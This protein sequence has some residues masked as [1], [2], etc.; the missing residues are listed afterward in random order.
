VGRSLFDSVRETTVTGVPQPVIDF[1]DEVVCEIPG[2]ITYQSIREKYVEVYKMSLSRTRL[3]TKFLEPLEDIGWLTHEPD[4]TDGRKVIFVKCRLEGESAET[5]DSCDRSYFRD[6]FPEERLKEYLG[7]LEEVWNLNVKCDGGTCEIE[8]GYNWF[9]SKRVPYFLE[10]DNGVE[11]GKKDEGTGK[12]ES[13]INGHNLQE[14]KEEYGTEQ[15]RLLDE[16]DEETVLQQ[17]P[18]DDTRIEDVLK[19]FEDQNRVV[20]TLAVLQ[21]KGKI[22]AGQG[23]MRRLVASGVESLDDFDV[24]RLS[25][26]TCSYC[27]ATFYAQEPFRNYDERAI[28]QKCWKRLI[29]KK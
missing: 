18:Q 6:I 4:P 24:S 1:Y 17:I 19:K 11:T 7:E 23:Y 9:F 14:K 12:C 2:S 5:A 22:I 15:Q 3:R 27:G 29:N 13:S 28:C 25:K 16:Y 20:D 26:W 10:E 8:D 21:D